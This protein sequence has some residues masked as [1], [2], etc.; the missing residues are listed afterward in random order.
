VVDRPEKPRDAVLSACKQTFAVVTWSPGDD[1]NALITGFVVYYRTSRDL[2][3]G[4]V[5]VG[6]RVGASDVLA[7]VRLAPWTEYWFSVAAVNEV[8][9][10]ERADVAASEPCE[11]QPGPPGRSPDLVCTRSQRPDQLVIVWE[12]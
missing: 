3:E 8:G 11:T 4:V 6:A 9:E 10:S 7:R 1:N 5:Q 12:V 2:E